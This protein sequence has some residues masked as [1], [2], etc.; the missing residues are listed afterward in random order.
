MIITYIFTIAAFV[1]FREDFTI[2]KNGKPYRYCD[3]MIYCYALLL[4]WT[5]KANG[6]IGGFLADFSPRDQHAV[7]G[8]PRESYTAGRYAFDNLFNIII[9]IIAVNIVAGTIID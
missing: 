8:D 6:G 1:W 7:S 5:F 2:E 4:D 3:D 9:V